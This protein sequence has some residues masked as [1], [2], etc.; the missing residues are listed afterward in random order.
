MILM[1]LMSIMGVIWAYGV[2]CAF[3]LDGKVVASLLQGVVCFTE[4][5]AGRLNGRVVI[6]LLQLGGLD[7]HGRSHGLSMGLGL[8]LNVVYRY[9]TGYR[10]YRLCSGIPPQIRLV[11]SRGLA[12]AEITAKRRSDGDAS[13]HC[14]SLYETVSQP[15]TI[16]SRG[17]L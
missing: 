15:L 8:R 14:R 12:R 11:F 1:G 3:C 7:G 16:D 10:L 9:Y 17:I 4:G 6:Y 13:T 2:C 5:Q